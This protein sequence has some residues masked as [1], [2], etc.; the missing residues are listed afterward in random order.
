MHLPK[1]LFEGEQWGAR[2]L[3]ESRGPLPLPL[4]PPL[5]VYHFLFGA[6]CY[7]VSI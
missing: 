2:P 6:C 1:I 7:N 3:T 5:A 4:E